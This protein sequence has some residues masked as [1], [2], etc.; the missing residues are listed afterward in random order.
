MYMP[1][2]LHDMPFDVFVDLSNLFLWIPYLKYICLPYRYVKSIGWC[3][4]N[5][6]STMTVSVFQ[7]NFWNQ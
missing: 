3:G 6:I 2:S 4:A 7:Q 5:N 1:I